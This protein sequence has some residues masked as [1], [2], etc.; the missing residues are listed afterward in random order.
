MAPETSV[1]FSPRPYLALFTASGRRV[2][3]GMWSRNSLTPGSARISRGRGRVIDRRGWSEQLHEH[4]FQ[5]V[6]P[7]LVRR[8][9]EMQTVMRHAVA[10]LIVLKRKLFV[11]VYVTYR[12]SI[13]Q[14]GDFPVCGR[15]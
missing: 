9:R 1:F 5:C 10:Q 6:G 15:C 7:V 8:R 4:G 11:D 13:G 12:L 3:G 14:C 2:F